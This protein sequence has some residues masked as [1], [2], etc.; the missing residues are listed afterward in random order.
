MHIREKN[1][2]VSEDIERNIEELSTMSALSGENFGVVWPYKEE[3]DVS[4]IT[5][6]KSVAEYVEL[7]TKINSQNI[8]DRDKYIDWDSIPNELRDACE[9][10]GIPWSRARAGYGYAKQYLIDFRNDPVSAL[11]NALKVTEV[12]FFF[13]EKERIA[14]REFLER[15]LKKVK[16]KGVAPEKVRVSY[17]G[18]PLTRD[19]L[20]TVLSDPDHTPEQ[21]LGLFENDFKKEFDGDTG[22]W[23][24][25][26]LREH[27]LMVMRQ[28]KKYFANTPIAD[29][30]LFEVVLALHDIG[31]PKAVIE[32]KK[33][34]QHSYT[35]EIM[36]S[37][38]SKLKYT[39]QQISI[40]ESIINGDPIRNYLSG[41]NIEKVAT[42]IIEN[43]RK[44]GLSVTQFWTLLRTYYLVDAGSYT[45]DAG[46]QPSLEHLFSFDNQSKQMD[47]SPRI[48]EMVDKLQE[49]VLRG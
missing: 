29:R 14:V 25:H 19:N 4:K 10:Y 45:A 12:K 27:T 47:F 38:L 11:T 44:S 39:E 26:T 42:A 37:V 35:Q 5:A 21:V 32:N 16:E 23:E 28:F 40:A 9:T 3:I 24:G 36:R 18:L 2:S 8:H 34:L 33:H 22:V 48:R 13:D 49:R 15:Q 41:E 6:P 17:E 31:K 1:A 7:A 46:S 43:A 30:N 20:D